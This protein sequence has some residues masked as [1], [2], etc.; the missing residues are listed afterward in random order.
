VERDRILGGL[1]SDRVRGTLL[2]HTNNLFTATS[3]HR[4]DGD[5]QD[6]THL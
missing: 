6:T 3:S 2:V 5:K 1:Q 4:E